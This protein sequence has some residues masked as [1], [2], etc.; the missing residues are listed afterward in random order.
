MKWTQYSI[1]LSYSFSIECLLYYH[2]VSQGNACSGTDTVNEVRLS[3]FCNGTENR[4]QDCGDG[5]K[6]MSCYC[7][8]QASLDCQPGE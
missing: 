7:R 2:T 1:I 5:V 4:L 6:E 8:T 3:T